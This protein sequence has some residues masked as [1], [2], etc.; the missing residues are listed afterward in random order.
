MRK[1]NNWALQICKIQDKGFLA[2]SRGEPRDA[3]PYRE[4]YSNQNGPGGQF[5]RQRRQSWDRGWDQGKEEQNA[6]CR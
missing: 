1:K 5:Q 3:N 2:G 6:N 4:G